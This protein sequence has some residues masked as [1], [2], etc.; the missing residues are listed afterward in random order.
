MGILNKHLSIKNRDQAN[1]LNRQQRQLLVIGFD[2]WRDQ[3][4]TNLNDILV[5]HVFDT[6]LLQQRLA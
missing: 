4:L 6:A 5:L 2:R 3:P 1:T